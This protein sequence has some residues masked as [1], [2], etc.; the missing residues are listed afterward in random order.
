MRGETNIDEIITMMVG[1]ELKH[2]S[3]RSATPGERIILSV[4]NLTTAKLRG[5]SFDLHEGEVLGV[6][7]LVGAGRSDTGTALF[8]LDRITQ[9]EI[10]L[11]GGAIAPRLRSPRNA[12][13]LGLCFLPEDR[14][15]QGLAMQAAVPREQ[16]SQRAVPF[17]AG[18][19]RSR[20]ELTAIKSVHT[21]RA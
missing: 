7:G 18:F 2:T 1:R 4:Q 10:H 8:G 9:G 16:Q 5:V 3:R 6:A 21:A 13:N 11:H 14:K 12:L 15:L 17:C 19:L 20:A